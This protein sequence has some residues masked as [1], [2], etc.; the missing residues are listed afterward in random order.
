MRNTFK[1]LIEKFDKRPLGKLRR[2]GRILLKGIPIKRYIFLFSG[3]ALFPVIIK[4]TVTKDQYV[5]QP[6][7]STHSKREILFYTTFLGN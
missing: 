6:R 4:M 7:S 5:E 2:K 1:D 3:F